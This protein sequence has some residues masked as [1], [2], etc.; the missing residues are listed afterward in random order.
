MEQTFIAIQQ[1]II[2]KEL[3]P[4][5]H[6]C[7]SLQEVKQKLETVGGFCKIAVKMDDE[8]Q[9]NLLDQCIF[10]QTGGGEVRGIVPNEE[11]PLGEH[12]VVRQGNE[13]ANCYLYIAKS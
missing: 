3:T 9:F 6:E 11:A 5:V 12:C 2:N 10:E 13:I 4:F 1:E 8:P 7:K